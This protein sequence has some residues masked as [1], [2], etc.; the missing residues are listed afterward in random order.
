MYRFQKHTDTIIYTYYIS[1]KSI[2]KINVC[3]DRHIAI[4]FFTDIHLPE[5]GTA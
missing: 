1:F 4:F 3:V 5:Q 2:K